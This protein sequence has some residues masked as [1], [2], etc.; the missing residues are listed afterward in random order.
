MIR[1]TGG[2]AALAFHFGRG[3]RRTAG[4]MLAAGLMVFSAFD[5]VA[6]YPERPIRIVIG[7]TAGASTD[8]LCR[9]IGAKLT[10]RFG[11]P[12]VVENRPGASARIAVEMVVKSPP[13][14]YSLTPITGISATYGLM[15]K[16]FSVEPKKDFTSV[17]LLGNAPTFLFV[18]QTV[19]A[20]NFAEFIAWAKAKGDIPYS[21]GGNGSASHLAAE[22]LIAA[23]GIKATPILYQG[24]Q[25]AGVAVASGEVAFALNNYDILQPFLGANARVKALAVME[26][27]RSELLPNVP[28]A[29]EVGMPKETEGLSPWFILAGPAGVSRDITLTLN[30]AINEILQ[31]KDV[32]DRLRA[33]AVE[34]GGGTPED[35]DAHWRNSAEKWL[36]VVRA[37]N[38]ELTP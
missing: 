18:S 32:R 14:G 35:A 29:A 36:R 7:S 15:F 25:P 2:S 28:T 13:D 4:A 16:D 22:A 24:N 5:A 3:L 9:L 1:N 27:K 37:K 34:V 21:S 8:T 31:M 20:N 33:I 10:E 6:A 30:R 19:P 38:I 11:Q 23:A 17:I 26:A 12:V